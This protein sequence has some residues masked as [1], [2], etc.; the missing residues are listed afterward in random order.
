MRYG[1]LFIGGREGVRGFLEG[2]EGAFGDL[3]PREKMPA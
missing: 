3:S 2:Y 1:P